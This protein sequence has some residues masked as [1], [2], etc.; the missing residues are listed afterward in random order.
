MKTPQYHGPIPRATIEAPLTR[1]FRAEADRLVGILNA[2]P[3]DDWTYRVHPIQGE[4]GNLRWQIA[5]YDE[6]GEFAGLF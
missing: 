4:T 6:D 3:E 2:E 5:A 1:Y